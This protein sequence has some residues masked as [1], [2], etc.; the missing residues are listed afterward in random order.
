[1]L[2]VF[3][4]KMDFIRRVVD[5]E[6]AAKEAANR[7]DKGLL[8]RGKSQDDLALHNLVWRLAE[9]WTSMT[10]RRPSAN[11]V[12]GRSP[13]DEDPEFVQLVKDPDFVQFVQYLVDLVEGAPK[14]SRKQIEIS[15]KNARTP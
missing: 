9:V 4:G 2:R 15:L 12:H 10:A 3:S 1:M 14:P 6:V 8:H 13:A 7:V 5:V 11:K